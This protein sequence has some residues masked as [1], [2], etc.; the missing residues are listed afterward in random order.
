MDLKYQILIVDDVA[1]NIQ[2]AMNILEEDNYDFSFATSGEAAYELLLNNEFDLVLLDIM[3][4]GIDGFELCQM[5]KRHEKLKDIPVIFLTA[6]VDIDSISHG[7]RVGGVDYITKPFQAEELIARVKNHLQLYTAK[8]ILKYH[9]ITLERKV[10]LSEERLLTELEKNQIEMIYIL[11]GLMESV[12]DESSEHVRRVAEISKLLAHYHQSLS[13]DD[14]EVIYHAAPMHDIGKIA[15]PQAILQKE[16]PLSVQEL[17]IVKKHTTKAHELLRNSSRKIM[18]AVDIIALEHHERWDGSG[19]P[20][21]LRGEDINILGRIVAVADVFDTL[22]HD[23]VY[24]KA[25]DAKKSASYI[26]EQSGKQFD[27]TVVTIFQEHL[28]EFLEIV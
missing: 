11:S 22:N 6:K 3:M 25:W 17:E 5:M 1:D 2:V 16:A 18:K 13:D 12:S 27:P 14:E 8:E 19:Y 15:V 20:K 21:G 28:D 9:N 24:A 26:I 23:R 7:F 4:P 10:K